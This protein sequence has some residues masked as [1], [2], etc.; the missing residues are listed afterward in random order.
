M[1]RC[2]SVIGCMLVLLVTGSVALSADE[3]TEKAVVFEVPTSGQIMDV[4]YIPEFEEWWVKCREGNSISVYSYDKRNRKWGRA[5]FIPVPPGEKTAKGKEAVKPSPKAAPPEQ[6]TGPS[7]ETN[8]QKMKPEEPKP[9]AKPPVEK[10]PPV[11]QQK[12]WDPFG[13]LKDKK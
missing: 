6:A 11:Q 1:S 3:K 13:L 4:V 7:T 8:E 2:I 10:A 5:R 12:W 9:A